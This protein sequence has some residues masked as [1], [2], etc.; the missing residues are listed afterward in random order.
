MIIK[1]VTPRK[2]NEY[3]RKVKTDLDQDTEAVRRDE[4]FR[5]DYYAF[6]CLAYHGPVGKLF[7][8]TTNFRQDLLQA[9]DPATHE[10]ECMRYQDF[11]KDEFEV[12]IHRSMALGND[13]ALYG[14]ASCLYPE[15][16]RLKAPGGKIFRFDYES[17]TFS[18]LSIPVKHDYIQTIT[19]DARREMIYG[20]TY[21]VFNFFAYSIPDNDVKYIQY[22]GSIPHLSAVDDDGGYWATWGTR[23]HHFFRYDPDGNDVKFYDHGF[24]TKCRNLMYPNAG[25]IDMALNIGDGSIYMASEQ[26]DLYKL[27]PANAE[28][29]YLGKPFPSERLPGLCAG[30]G[31]VMYCAGGTDWNVRTAWYDLKTGS[32]HDLGSVKDSETG[33]PCFRA[34]DLAVVGNCLYVGETDHPERSNYLWEIELAEQ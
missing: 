22:M 31:D 15:K 17:R 1:S 2:L 19:L 5:R 6:T 14:A 24:P 21:P 33:E 25:P 28:L 12:K 3:K 13:G 32:F 34:H 4:S 29:E 30:E 20:F 16:Y 23:C 27:N 9:Y 10:F 18:L 8:G 7:C 11:S 26:A